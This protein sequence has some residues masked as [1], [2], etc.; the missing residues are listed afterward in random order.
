MSDSVANRYSLPNVP[1]E[2]KWGLG[3][4]SDVANTLCIGNRPV[5]ILIVGELQSKWFSNDQGV[6]HRNASI[7]LAPINA[8]DVDLA[9]GLANRYARFNGT[10]STHDAPAS[11]TQPY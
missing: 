10:S 8:A 2:A 3:A 11:L 4:R 9:K 7:S 1:K 5:S 6:P